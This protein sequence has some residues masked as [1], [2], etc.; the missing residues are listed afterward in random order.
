[1]DKE[2][3]S[4]PIINVRGSKVGLGPMTFEHFKNFVQYEQDPDVAIFGGGTFRAFD[5]DVTEENFKQRSK[6]AVQF[7]IFELEQLT[8]IGLT[9]LRGVDQLNGTA[10]FGISI[11]RKDYWGHGYGTEATK[12]TLD[13]AFRFLNLYNVKLRTA[14]YNERGQGAYKRAGFKEMGR[15]RGSILV[16]GKRYDEVYMD[17]LASEFASP[18]PGWTLPFQPTP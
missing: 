18:V 3:N 16:S 8:L 15:R 5:P 13:Y 6:D 7:A 14:S 4:Q 1:M 2:I 10:T 9:T 11:G 17:C 12:L